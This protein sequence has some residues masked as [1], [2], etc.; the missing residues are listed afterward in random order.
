MT[1]DTVLVNVSITISIRAKKAYLDGEKFLLV[2]S[3]KPTQI[4]EWA[5]LYN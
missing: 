4:T 1:D 3:K 5:F 2:Q